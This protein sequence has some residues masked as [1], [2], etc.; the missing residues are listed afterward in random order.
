M[1]KILIINID[2]AYRSAYTALLVASLK[3]DHPLLNCTLITDTSN[4]GMSKTGLFEN[5]LSFDVQKF[6][7]DTKNSPNETLER[8]LKRL[9]TPVLNV[10]WDTVVNL[11]SNMLG[12]MLTHF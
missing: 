2:P 5:V 1:N 11:S 10:E 7:Q 8:E 6:F 12:S 3:K 4:E 9:V